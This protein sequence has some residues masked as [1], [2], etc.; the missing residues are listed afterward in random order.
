VAIG[1]YGGSR[2][3]REEKT[4]R[5]RNRGPAQSP[6]AST[7][8]NIGVLGFVFI[9]N[10]HKKRKKQETRKELADLVHKKHKSSGTG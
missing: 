9:P 4:T 7:V 5:R 6:G 2:M 1:P 8:K 10:R 3:T